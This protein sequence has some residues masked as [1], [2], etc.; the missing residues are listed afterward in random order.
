[1]AVLVAF[2]E[3]HVAKSVE[4]IHGEVLGGLFAVV[5]FVGYRGETFL[6][7]IE[8]GYAA[9]LVGGGL[10]GQVGGGQGGLSE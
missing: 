9:V 10:E 7:A 1:M 2:H 3:S 4:V 6:L 5:V 8:F